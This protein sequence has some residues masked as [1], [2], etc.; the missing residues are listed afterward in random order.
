LNL[1]GSLLIT[2]KVSLGN[3]MASG[4]LQYSDMNGKCELHNVRVINRGID[5]Q[6]KN[7]FWKNEIKHH[8]KLEIILHGN[9]E[10]FAKDVCFE[11]N[12][13][14]EVPAGCRME[15]TVHEGRIQ[16]HSRKI[17]SPTWQ[18]RYRFDS[19]DAIQLSKEIKDLNKTNK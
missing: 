5:W 9:G 16:Y 2:A 18:W 13:R 12:T 4:L 19:K 11:G 14:I 6:A 7:S 15:V 8:E 1:E 3:L 10:F 17:N